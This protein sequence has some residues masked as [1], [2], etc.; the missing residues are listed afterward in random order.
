MLSLSVVVVESRLEKLQEGEVRIA[1]VV[2]TVTRYSTVRYCAWYLIWVRAGSDTLTLDPKG[3]SAQ[4]LSH[5]LFVC[6]LQ[7]R[8][9]YR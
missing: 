6:Q 9:V 4:A 1:M 8:R 2:A 5:R 3:L 7:Y